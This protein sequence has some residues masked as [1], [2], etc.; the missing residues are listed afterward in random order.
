M[1]KTI[2]YLLQQHQAIK[3]LYTFFILKNNKNNKKEQK[4]NLLNHYILLTCMSIQVEYQE[5]LKQNKE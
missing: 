1:K 5:M 4:Y 3:Y 2:T